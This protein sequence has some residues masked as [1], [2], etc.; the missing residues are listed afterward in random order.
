MANIRCQFSL[1]FLFI[2]FLS[3][4][5][6]TINLSRSKTKETSKP[7]E[8]AHFMNLAILRNSANELSYQIEIEQMIA[9]NIINSLSKENIR[10]YVVIY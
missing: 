5:T 1:L 10:K 9:L 6:D 4:Q 3:N 7:Q 8:Q 2:L